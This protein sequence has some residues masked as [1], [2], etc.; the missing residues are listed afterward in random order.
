MNAKAQTVLRDADLFVEMEKAFRRKSREC[1][2]CTFSMPF[3]TDDA[4]LT[5][6]WSMMPAETCSLDCRMIFEDL[7]A[8]YQANYTLSETGTF[9]RVGDGRLAAN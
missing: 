4:N 3:R 8:E 6:N 2:A 5:S 9:Y 1:K 7:L